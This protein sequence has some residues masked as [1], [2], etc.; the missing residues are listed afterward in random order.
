MGILDRAIR[1]GVNRAIG[2]AVAKGVEQAV[3]PHVEKAAETLTENINEA[4]A[5]GS[6]VNRAAAEAAAPASGLFSSLQGAATQLANEAAKNMKICPS[7][8]E[9]AGAD[10]KFCPSCGGA[11]PEGTVAEGAVC[12]KCGKQNDVGTKFCAECGERL[13]AALAEEQAA[14]QK[15]AAVMAEW[16]EKL[17]HYP[18]WSCGG[19]YFE[20]ETYDVDCYSFSAVF[21]SGAAAMEGVKQYRN[22][23]QQSGFRPA[24][25][26]PGEE[27]LY[28]MI[29][30]VCYHVDTEHCFEGDPECIRIG[31]SVGEPA[32]GFDYVK[33]EPKKPTSLRD[34]LNL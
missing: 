33:P 31:F 34:L 30:G 11:L 29:G 17:P 13:P 23:L 10:K 4:A 12:A 25:Q 8:G 28:N 18:V 20:L 21:P 7:C 2:D 9:P 22:L 15:D 6:E 14:A 1:R 5:A 16:A 27:H 19:K 26:Y 24:G 32:G 3:A